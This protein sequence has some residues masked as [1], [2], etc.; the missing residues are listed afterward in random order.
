MYSYYGWGTSVEMYR[1]M[2]RRVCGVN[3]VWTLVQA[4]RCSGAAGNV[5]KGCSL[6]A[7]IHKEE[8]IERGGPR[9]EWGDADRRGG[10]ERD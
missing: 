7:Q 6:R 8:T 4:L 2:A 9:R 3:D 10:C 5:R 1:F